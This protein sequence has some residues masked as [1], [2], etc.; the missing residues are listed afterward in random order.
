LHS[1]TSHPPIF[2]SVKEDMWREINIL[3]NRCSK[4]SKVEL[5]ELVNHTITKRS[6]SLIEGGDLDHR[7]GF[8][9]ILQLGKSEVRVMGT[10]EN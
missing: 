7:S 10:H 8:V 3:L 9:E 1:I 5:Q 2:R 6:L 4:E